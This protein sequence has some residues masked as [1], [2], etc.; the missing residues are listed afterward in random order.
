MITFDVDSDKVKA[1]PAELSEHFSAEKWKERFFA[2]GFVPLG[3]KEGTI[4]AHKLDAKDEFVLMT[5]SNP[6]FLDTCR[7]AY[8]EHVPLVLSPD[9]VWLTMAQAVSKHI[10]LNAEDCRKALVPFEGKRELI[11]D[12]PFI[13]GS[14]K[15]DW[16]WAFSQFGKQIEEH[17][18]KKRDLF[19]P[20]FST[21]TPTS[22]A[23]IQV[24]LMAAVSS[25]FDYRGRT[26]CGIP[27]ITLLGEIEDWASILSRVNAFGEFYPKWAHEPLQHVAANFVRAAAGKPDLQFWRNFV[28]VEGGSGGPFVSGFING[29]YPYTS[30]GRGAVPNRML[31]SKDGKSFIDTVMT[32]TWGPALADFPPSSSAVDMKWDY[33][34][35]EYKMKLVAGIFGT[36]IDKSIHPT[37]AYRPLIGWVVGEA[38]EQQG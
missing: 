18:G 14:Q 23:A 9:D 36:N 11:V 1:E 27:Q 22:K 26:C 31:N 17:L 28:K 12:L 5:P 16:E 6:S 34:G 35:T 20:T 30:Y 33:L 24:Q 13:K 3:I 7:M 21:T 19:D 2:K 29:L 37:G 10:Q 32:R 15:N 25:F 38:S 4:E 8:D